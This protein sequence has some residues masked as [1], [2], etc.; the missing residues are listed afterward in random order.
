[1]AQFEEGERNGKAPENRAP[2]HVHHYLPLPGAQNRGHNSTDNRAEDNRC[3][4][5]D[6]ADAKAL[7]DFNE[8][9]AFFIKN[10]LLF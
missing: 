6:A 10:G 2:E 7:P 3:D 9:A 4:K 5:R 8:P 1:M